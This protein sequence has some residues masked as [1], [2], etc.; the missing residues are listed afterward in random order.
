MQ[1]IDIAQTVKDIPG[2]LKAKY[3][4]TK[5]KIKYEIASAK[6]QRLILKSYNDFEK[7]LTPATKRQSEAFF[8]KY[9]GPYQDSE[10]VFPA[11]EKFQDNTDY[12]QEVD[13]KDFK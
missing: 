11:G 7:E 12:M 6:G 3:Y 2:F 8:N 10:P 9:Y 5:H 13:M 1:T 4:Q